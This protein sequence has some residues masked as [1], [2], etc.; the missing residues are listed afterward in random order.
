MSQPPAKRFAC[1]RGLV[2]RACRAIAEGGIPAAG[3]LVGG[4]VAGPGGIIAGSAIGQLFYKLAAE[5]LFD[6]FRRELP[7]PATRIADLNDTV[8]APRAEIEATVR[9]VVDQAAPPD[10][11]PE[12][13]EQ[14][15]AWMTQI[16][17]QMR[18]TFRRPSDRRG[19]S[20]ERS[21]APTRDSDLL[22]FIPPRPPLF[23]PGQQLPSHPDWRLDD[24][25][26][27]G[28]FGE[29]WSAT[30]EFTRDRAAFKFCTDES[31]APFLRHE[32]RLLGRLRSESALIDPGIVS[33]HDTSL[34]ATPPW[35]R[36][37]LIDGGDLGSLITAWHGEDSPF[38]SPQARTAAVLRLFERIVS[39]VAACHRQSP[40]IVHRDLKP[41]NILIEAN[42]ADETAPRPRVT[43]FGIGGA[44]RS[45]GAPLHAP[46]S[47]G[48]ARTATLSRLLGTYTE[49]FASPQQRAG[50][51]PH[52]ADDVFSL[53]VIA[54]QMIG[55]D[56]SVGVPSGRRWRGR[57]AEASGV[58]DDVLDLL[59]E[60]LEHERDDRPA[61][62]GKLLTAL[63]TAE[64]EKAREEEAAAAAARAKAEQERQE[65]E[66]RAR[67]EQEERE[68][69]DR[70]VVR[71]AEVSRQ[72]E[73]RVAAKA[74][75]EAE[76]R[77]RQREDERRRSATPGAGERRVVDL[78]GDVQMALRRIPAKAFTMGSPSSEE[79]RSSD[80]GPQ[81]RVTLTSGFWMGE[82]EVTQ[83]Q[84]ERIM[85]ANPSSFKGATLPVETV[86]WN[87]A[88]AF[89][90]K[91][92]RHLGTTVRLPTEAEWEYACRA[93][94]TTRFHFGDS[95]SQLGDY[96]WYNGN[97]GGKTRPVGQKHANAWGL[98]D[99]HGNVW[100]W[101]S[102][103]Y[104][105]KL[106]GGNVR[107]PGGP[108]SG[109]LR[110]RR[111]GCWFNSA[112]HCR[113]A[114]RFRLWPFRTLSNLGFRV[115]A[116]PAG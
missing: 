33:L 66:V 89:C 62:A 32:A 6:D 15:V 22:R 65:A 115:V 96:A 7:D 67:R 19:L 11:P 69:A 29:V 98:H 20:V 42:S 3:G 1:L 102:D 46:H 90:E 48:G 87:D 9:A 52:P 112:Q 37:E 43:D 60:C 94:T 56:Q 82:T 63:R 51:D 12:Q 108:F 36:Y 10:L 101:C 2:S 99:M 47:T 104:N 92:S 64:T 107:D 35:L 80:E 4:V 26:G 91:L 97:A 83:A 70:E 38:T 24:M 8:N 76:E 28:G 27:S 116:V 75:R 105:D 114:N 58:P 13:K 40:P 111:G 103:W 45:A 72:E 110:V 81:T 78:G 25:L 85:G 21:L 44:V 55:G 54:L 106:P 31:V 68:K 50:G 17:A 41:S 95:D 59:E 57:L 39:I 53:G 18:A 109:S 84:Y 79:G 23:A 14:L 61:D 113:S 71:L 34:G 86:S 77:E 88:T 5:P 49:Q 100:E 74:K 30:N 16:P 73:A 93:G